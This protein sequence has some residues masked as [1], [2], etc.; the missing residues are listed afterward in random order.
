MPWSYSLVS[1]LHC[2]HALLLATSNFIAYE[3]AVFCISSLLDLLIFI[4]ALWTQRCESAI[5]GLDGINI[6][7]EDIP[8]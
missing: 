7:I 6:S 3:P 4:L 8:K 5:H 1:C 2:T